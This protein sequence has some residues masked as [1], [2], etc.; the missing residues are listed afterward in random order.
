M[1]K[2]T[3]IA[4]TVALILLSVAVVATAADAQT[5]VLTISGMHCEGCASGIEAM[6][7]RTEGVIKVDVS[8]E[9]RE[10]TVQ[11]DP[12]KASPEKVIAAI[13]KMGY[14]AAVKK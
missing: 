6:V 13:E 14:K 7:K 4:I 3:R 10:A 11:Y 8:Y 9:A 5:V 2:K 12:A 1:M